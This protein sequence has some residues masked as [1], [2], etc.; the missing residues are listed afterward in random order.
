M[1]IKKLRALL[2][3][4]QNALSTLFQVAAPPTWAELRQTVR[5]VRSQ[6]AFT[7]LLLLFQ[8]EF[9]HILELDFL[10]HS[11][12]I[13]L[14]FSPQVS[15]R[16][17]RTPSCLTFRKTGGRNRLYF[18]SEPGNPSNQIIP[19]SSPGA[20]YDCYMIPWPIVLET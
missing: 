8:D 20:Y 5:D 4:F 9:L 11:C 7:C 17:L 3:V 12:P 14:S 19:P 6:V 15:S 10:L 18:L 13:F 16:G 2:G 1:G